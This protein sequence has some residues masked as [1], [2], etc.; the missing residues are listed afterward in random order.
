MINRKIFSLLFLILFAVFSG[1]TQEE[2]EI[3][4]IGTMHQ[5]PGVIKRPTNPC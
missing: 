5:V 4:I 2:Q 1:K 3:L